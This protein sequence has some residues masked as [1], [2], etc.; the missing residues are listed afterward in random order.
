MTCLTLSVMITKGGEMK[1]ITIDPANLQFGDHVIINK[2]EYAVRF[3][4]GPD[5]IGTYDVGI[6]DPTGEQKIVIVTEPVTII[7]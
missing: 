2:H 3:V 4:S 5:R 7:V 6:Q 1:T